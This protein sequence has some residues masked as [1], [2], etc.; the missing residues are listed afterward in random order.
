MYACLL[1][2]K[3]HFRTIT[4]ASC[5]M[6]CWH[7][8]GQ[9]T[10]PRKWVVKCAAQ[11]IVDV[12]TWQYLPKCSRRPC[13]SPIAFMWPLNTLQTLRQR[14]IRWPRLTKM[15]IPCSIMLNPTH[16]IH[17]Y[18]TP[19]WRIVERFAFWHVMW[20]ALPYM[21]MPAMWSHWEFTQTHRAELHPPTHMHRIYI[22]RGGRDAACQMP[23]PHLNIERDVPLRISHFV[24]TNGGGISM[25][26][27]PNIYM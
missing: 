22:V 27:I 19:F 18:F 10:S 15:M 26:S 7:L 5:S 20:Y 11:S 1:D 17:F 16:R 2:R 6:V 12:T 3:M 23:G 8:C 9:M 24:D 13:G 4:S 25:G 14:T 21:N